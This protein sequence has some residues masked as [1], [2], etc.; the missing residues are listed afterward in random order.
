ML[1]TQTSVDTPPSRRTRFRVGLALV[2]A[3]LTV[4]GCGGRQAPTTD[5]TE[6][7]TATSEVPA[8]EGSPPAESS[9]EGASA[10]GSSTEGASAGEGPA[11][12]ESSEEG[13]TASEP[14]EPESS[15]TGVG[16]PETEPPSAGD[17][18]AEAVIVEDEVAAEGKKAEKEGPSLRE[19]CR[20]DQVEGEQPFLETSRRWLKVN[21][22]GANLWLDGLF[23]GE[24]DV[25]NARAISGRLIIRP[26]YS[27]WEGFDPDVKLRVE[28]DLPTLE[29]RLEIFLGRDDEEDFVQDR[30]PGLIV[31]STVFG[32]ETEDRWLAGLGYRPP[33]KYLQ[34]FDFSVGGKLR[35]A[36]EVFVKGRYRR[37]FFLGR[38]SVLRIRGTSFWENRDG[39]GGTASF[40]LDSV[41]MGSNLLRLS[42]SGTLS[43]ESSGLEW[44]SAA[45][46]YQRLEGK[47]PSAL[48]YEAFVRGA[49]DHEV[50]LREFGVRTIYRRA[51]FREWFYG[52]LIAGYSWP[53][54]F[55]EE[56]REGSGLFGVGIELHF[57]QDPY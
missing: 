25:E 28:Y 18:S 46:F 44:R 16:S 8:S 47:I 5:P 20:E 48:A 19:L 43:E 31:D 40:D 41:V 49:T 26:T 54:E 3:G 36:P 33:G 13:E 32:L 52:E 7:S 50:E 21:L 35:S 2:L 15:S 27:E 1:K 12:A 24:P 42:N 4:A 6:I 9:T 56:K 11:G 22:C 29:R 10:E 38:H 17:S 30:R 53:R 55:I 39:F 23:G 57:G 34:R 45:L 14:A 37:N 51:M